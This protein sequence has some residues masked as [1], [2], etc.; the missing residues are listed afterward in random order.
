MHQ[1]AIFFEKDFNVLKVDQ[2]CFDESKAKKKMDLL[3]KIIQLED[4]KLKFIG[5]IDSLKAI[6]LENEKIVKNSR[7]TFAI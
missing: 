2:A 7:K 4:D 3:K 5:L 1:K 6:N